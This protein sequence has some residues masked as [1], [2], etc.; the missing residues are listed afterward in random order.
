MKKGNKE[1]KGIFFSSFSF[2][3]TTTTMEFSPFLLFI[4]G[5]YIF[6]KKM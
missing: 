2:S 4:P 1:K 5:P 6:F 3:T